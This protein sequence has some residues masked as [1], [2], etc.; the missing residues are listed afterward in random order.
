MVI[1]TDCMYRSSIAV[2][3]SLHKLGEEIVAVTTDNCKNPPAFYS[4]Y[5][6]ECL[7]LP[8]EE[9]DYLNELKNLCCKYDRP[10]IFP[11]GVF[12]L[13]VISKHKKELD[14]VADFAVADTDI[15]DALNDKKQSKEIA[16]KAF[17]C[18]PK[19]CDSFPMVVKPF[20]GEKFGLKA[21]ERYRIVKNESELNDALSFF[22]D[23][24]NSPIIEEYID[25]YGV[26]V[27]VV[28]GNDGVER[29]AFC[30]RR[31]SEYPA[32]G[33]PSSCLVTFNDEEIMQKAINMLKL[34]GFVGIAMVEF[35]VSNGNYFFLEVNPRIWGSFGATFKADSDFVK[36]YL[37]A[38]RGTK[39]PFAPRY[40]IKKI[41]FVPNIFA[42][43]ISYAKSNQTKKAFHT[44]IDALN[45]FVPNAI[46]SIFDPIPSIMD[47]FRKRR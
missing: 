41:K 38:A 26:G 35:K 19:K 43:V 15:L 5:P 22:S 23:Y 34:S 1:V 16:K 20:C 17:I 37:S 30:H 42:S 11:V 6:K 14:A 13:N 10:V 33:G 39:Y 47:I 46:F 27:S 18:V 9:A 40:K 2:I 21:S 12:T 7:V 45:P 44:L 31:L 8:S 29:S 36:A 3:Y 24:D 32:C 25:G 4:R 28:I